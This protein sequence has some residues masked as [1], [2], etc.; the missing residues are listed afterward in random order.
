MNINYEI[1]ALLKY[2]VDNSLISECDRV[3]CA[4]RIIA[5]LGLDEFELVPVECESPEYPAPILDNI[6]D[7]AYE[8]GVLQGNSA[9]YRDI[10]D[11]EIMSVFIPHPSEVI[12]EFNEKYAED[13]K[14]A[15]DYFYNLATKSNYIHMDRIAKNIIWTT[16]TKYGDMIISINLSKPEKDPKEIAAALKNKSAS[17][18]PKCLLCRENEGYKGTLTHPARANHRIIPLHI[19]GE[20]WFL[21]YSPYV[22]YNEHCIMFKA[23]HEP[24]KISRQTF[25][26]L[27]GFVEYMP[28]YFIGSNAGLPIVGGSILAHD[29][30]QGGN[31]DFPMARAGVYK[32]VKFKGYD[33][34]EAGLVDWPMSVIRIRHE[35]KDVLVDLAYKILIAWEG[36]TDEAAY[37]LA[38]TDGVP[39]N[40]ITPIARHKSGKYELDLVLRNNITDEQYPQGVYHPHP[41]YHHIKKENIGLIE[42]MG[43]AIL[44]ARLK[45]SIAK[46]EYYLKNPEKED[47]LKNDESMAVHMD[48]Y[49]QLKALNLPENRI[50]DGIKQSVGEI[51][52]AILE[53]AGV[54]K[55]NDD[56]REAFLRFINYCNR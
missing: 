2:A 48:W 35:D 13:K 16:D 19:A 24:M 37:I 14:A 3:Y 44:P 36:Y 30:Y 27:L 34:V 49:Y 6:L 54:Y 20:D 52:A 42:V 41:E 33:D 53:N 9:S 39:H 55:N 15:S 10:L 5:L 12:R 18:Y 26:R 1:S 11:A 29:H 50:A 17:K 21:Q 38:E 28:H 45:D 32:Q 22:Y 7:W 23:A 8:N 31:F 4:N 47:E 25:A 46:I 43:L 51:F 40:A 56:G